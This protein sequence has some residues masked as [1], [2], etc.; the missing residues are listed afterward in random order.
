MYAVATLATCCL[1][2]TILNKP[3]TYMKVC[4]T[5]TTAK[6][7]EGILLGTARMFI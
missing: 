6:R 5:F 3:Q 4:A 2:A 7:A 1:I